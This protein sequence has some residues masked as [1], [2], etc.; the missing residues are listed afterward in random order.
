MEIWIKEI[1]KTEC[2]INLATAKERVDSGIVNPETTYAWYEGLEEWVVLKSIFPPIIVNQL[3]PIETIGERIPSRNSNDGIITII[4]TEADKKSN[5]DIL[6]E[7]LSN[8]GVFTACL[9]IAFL[10][11]QFGRDSGNNVRD[12]APVMWICII[13]I[14]IFR[15]ITRIQSEKIILRHKEITPLALYTKSLLRSLGIV[16]L[17]YFA[18]SLIYIILKY[19]TYQI[20]SVVG[21]L[22]AGFVISLLFGVVFSVGVSISVSRKNKSNPIKKVRMKSVIWL[23]I[24]LGTIIIMLFGFISVV[25]QRL[26]NL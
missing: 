18:I 3:I 9:H 22:I 5:I 24:G 15:R 11:A 20:S 1:D 13:G 17:M 21:N 25:I 14:C 23:A 16:I 12:S 2:L 8:I 7:L 19:E 4:K 10:T 6:Y 26:Q